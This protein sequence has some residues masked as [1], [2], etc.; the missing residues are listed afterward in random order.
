M[1][2]EAPMDVEASPRRGVLAWPLVRLIILTAAVVLIAI[3]ATILTRLLV[4]PIPSP[5]HGLVM[6]KNLM[7][8][9]AELAAYAILVQWLERRRAGE[10]ALGRD[11]LRS[12]TAG[13]LVGAAAICT[14]IMILWLSGLATFAT[15]T[16][17]AGLANAILVPF[18]TAVIEEILFRAILFRLLEEM[19]GTLSA[20]LL[21]A[22]LFGLAHIGNAGATVMAILFLSLSLGLL[23]ALAFAASRSLWM[24]IGL[25]LGWNFALSYLFGTLNS[26]EAAPSHLLR[27]TFS[28]PPLLTGGSFGLEASMVTVLLAIPLAGAITMI[29]RRRSDW[30]PLP[31][32]PRDRARGD[33]VRH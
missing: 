9:I 5:W 20:A 26:G 10:V 4:P 30:R 33:V 17:T 32:S 31:L 23:T 13:L 11:G 2:N 18:T 15:G 7:L 24:P 14:V 8:P 27:T 22:A 29:A 1:S 16:G 6:I 21:S 25:H 3:I 12:L 19:I 28:G